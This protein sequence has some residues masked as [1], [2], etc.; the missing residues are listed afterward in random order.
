MDTADNRGF[1][2]TLCDVV[3]ADDI[4]KM[5]RLQAEII[6]KLLNAST[7]LKFHN[8]RS[9][10]YYSSLQGSFKA[11]T[12]AVEKIK[13]DL[14]QIY[15]RTKKIKQD[16][17]ALGFDV[18]QKSADND[19]VKRMELD[20]AVE[21]AQLRSQVEEDGSNNIT[22]EERKDSEQ[23]PTAEPSEELTSPGPVESK[24]G[25]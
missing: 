23:P 4:L 12:K 10:E 25:K 17:K 11:H 5:D 14:M 3:C 18:D 16:L 6:V 15:K 22:N 2:E 1:V 9:Q 19:D 24:V 8:E 20:A 21:Q 7:F 13:D